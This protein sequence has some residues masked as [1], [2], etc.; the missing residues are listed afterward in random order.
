MIADS[1]LVPQ[2]SVAPRSFGGLMALYESNYIKLDALIGGL[3]KLRG[4]WTSV[5][6]GDLPLQLLVDECSRYTRVIRL[7]Y[8]IPDQRGELLDPDL[9]LRIYLDARMAEVTGWAKRHRHAV[10]SRLRWQ[11]RRELDRRWSRNIML[12]KWLDYLW[13]RGHGSHSLRRASACTQAD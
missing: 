13:E 12:S 7:T 1:Y 5:T 9:R 6:A 4:R 2:G 3:E 11:H 8:L 10:L